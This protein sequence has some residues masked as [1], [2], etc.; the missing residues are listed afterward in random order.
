MS[1]M[2]SSP[3]FFECQSGSTPDT[4]ADDT[5]ADSVQNSAVSRNSPIAQRRL[6]SPSDERNVDDNNNNNNCALLER[7]HNQSQEL[8]LELVKLEAEEE[9]E[10]DS[11][12]SADEVA[13]L[14]Y[15]M[16]KAQN[17]RLEVLMPDS[18]ID[19]VADTKTNSLVVELLGKE[20]SVSKPPNDWKPKPPKIEFEEPLFVEVDN[21]GAWCEFTFRPKYLPKK[22]GNVR[23]GTYSHHA[24][25]TGARPV[26]PDAEGNRRIAGWDFYYDKWSNPDE[27][28]GMKFRSGATRVNPF[29]ENR[30]GNLDYDLLKKMGLTKTRLLN[31]DALFFGSFSSPFAI[32]KGPGYRMTLDCRSTRK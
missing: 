18:G 4:A 25:P 16:M 21:P 5:P 8:D 19:I 20:V 15:S 31:H 28:G 24:L 2:E 12:C 1:N 29:P 17:E 9:G 3:S 26:P 10:G 22:V 13:V 30:K 7:L 23:K 11:N 6:F 32:R 14:N 27:D